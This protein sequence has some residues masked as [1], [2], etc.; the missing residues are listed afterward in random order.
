MHFP[1]CLIKYW[2]DYSTECF[3]M[4]MKSTKT[5]TATATTT[6][7]RKE[8]A[9]KRKNI[10]TQHER[11]FL[12]YTFFIALILIHFDYSCESKR[13]RQCKKKK[14]SQMFYSGD[15]IQNESPLHIYKI[16]RTTCFSFWEQVVLVI[17]H[18]IGFFH[19]V[20][21]GKHFLLAKEFIA[22]LSKV[23]VFLQKW[24]TLKFNKICN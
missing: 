18:L 9:R 16:L 15:S 4:K 7:E 12:L 3:A 6:T 24:N 22:L 19:R 21:T 13:R 17:Q 20:D 8:K 14:S 23:H 10:H 11:Q 2:Q 5:M 1:T